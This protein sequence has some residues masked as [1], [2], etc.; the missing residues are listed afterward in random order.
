LT[1]NIKEIYW[2]SN[3]TIANR[4]PDLNN[5]TKTEMAQE[6]ISNLSSMSSTTAVLTGLPSRPIEGQFGLL[7]YQSRTSSGRQSTFAR[8]CSI[9]REDPLEQGAVLSHAGR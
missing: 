1:N 8:I 4:S 9:K 7:L 6:Y 5:G 3:I 2:R